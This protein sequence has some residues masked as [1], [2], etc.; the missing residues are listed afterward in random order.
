M[1][2]RTLL[3][4]VGATGSLVV[5]GCL[6]TDAD[7]TEDPEA[8]GGP[9]RYG[10]PAHSS[11]PPAH[12]YD[13]GSVVSYHL[14]LSSLPAIR[15]AVSTGRLDSTNPLVGLPLSGVDRI[16]AAVESLSSY[17][18]GAALRQAVNAAGRVDDEYADENAT[19]VDPSTEPIRP[20]NES[21]ADQR[22]ETEIDTNSTATADNANSTET[23]D[24][25]STN[26]SNVTAGTDD[27]S[28][29]SELE[30]EPE[31][32]TAA[33]VGIEV[34]AV[35]LTDG[36]LVFEGSFDHSEIVDRFGWEF[37][38]VDSQRGVSIYEGH[39]DAAG[40]AF[41]LT[42]TRLFV[43]T[44]D[45]NRAADGRRVL[46]HVLSGYIS[47]LNRIVDEDDGQWLFE[48]TGEGTLSVCIWEQP[49]TV[50][51]LTDTGVMVELSS[52]YEAIFGPLSSCIS[53]LSVT[54]DSQRLT[55][56]EARFSGLFPADPP[57]EE[58][59]QSTLVVDADPQT[60]FSEPPRAHV[61]ATFSSL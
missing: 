1:N 9:V 20:E 59:L 38:H 31:S 5:A 30:S 3:Q 55:A 18:F 42:G 10:R 44:E 45:P 4:A 16:S 11:W 29:G 54:A 7:V 41:G 32:V 6:E 43:P 61:T 19:V 27:Q 26:E 53:T 35:M 52:E 46:A 8:N 48:T 34:D 37:E 58:E 28:A 49:D 56:A 50:E 23:A 60:V 12:S 57:A 47:T 33:D 24:E 40:L 51:F 39:S 36:L 17:P 14:E 25:H 2:R 13:N 15:R 21:A 22:N